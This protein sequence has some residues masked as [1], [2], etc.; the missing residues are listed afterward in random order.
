MVNI[1]VGERNQGKTTRLI[2][3]YE[4]INK[5][6][7][8]VS[9][10]RMKNGNIIGYDAIQLSNREKYPFII[11]EDYLFYNRDFDNW[12]NGVSLGPYRFSNKTFNIIEYK[13]EDMLKKRIS[14]I[15]LDEIGLL[16]I[17]NCGFDKI[18]R[19]ILLEA[20]EIYIATRDKFVHKVIKKYS[21]KQIN[22][23]KL[24]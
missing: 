18:F 11:R 14:P 12:D 1:V 16:E 2:K 13:I 17:K 22:I 4:K 10:K 8:F 19:K 23:L 9:V 15:F 3:I 7:G 21:I 24:E 5:G 6:D 20:N